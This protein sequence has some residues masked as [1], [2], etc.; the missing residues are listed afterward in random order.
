MHGACTV[1][2]ATCMC[3]L[4]ILRPEALHGHRSRDVFLSGPCMHIYI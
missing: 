4:A 1:M 3:M 2:N